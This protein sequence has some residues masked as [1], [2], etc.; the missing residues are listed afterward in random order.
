MGGCEGASHEDKEISAS[1]HQSS[2]GIYDGLIAK[3]S[4]MF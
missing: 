3:L 4:S 1:S 2:G